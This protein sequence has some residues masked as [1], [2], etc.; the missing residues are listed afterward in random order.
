MI[1]VDDK[2]IDLVEKIRRALKKGALTPDN[3]P[4]D[5][6]NNLVECTLGEDFWECIGSQ[7]NYGFGKIPEIYKEC[8]TEALK[9]KDMEECERLLHLFEC[10]YQAF[11]AALN[12]EEKVFRQKPYRQMIIDLG[13][14][15]SQM[16]YRLHK[17]RQKKYEIGTEYNFGE[18]RGVIYT[19]MFGETVVRQPEEISMQVDYICFTDKE[20]KWGE[21]NG[22]WQ[23]RRMEKIEKIEGLEEDKEEIKQMFLES[24]CKIMAHELLKEYD[25]SIW[26]DPDVV[27]VGDILRFCKVYGGGKSFLS[28]P[29]AKEDCIYENMSVTQMGTNDLNIKVRKMMLFYRKKGYPEHYGSIDGR[30]MV[31]NHKDPKLCRIMAEWWEEVKNSFIL[32]ENVFNYIAWK[33]EF[34]FSVCNLFVYENPYFKVTGIDL[35][36]HE[37]L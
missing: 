29:S 14:V 33:N 10:I 8:L 15:N 37:E 22:V 11:Y 17:E 36:T 27:I 2:M 1:R 4:M 24:K 3:F 19:C 20:E 13:T 23:Y 31:R 9:R 35:D 12:E 16:Q 28:F 7:P 25:Y 26:V 18:G 32:I 30:V 34:P 21:K 6:I 5:E